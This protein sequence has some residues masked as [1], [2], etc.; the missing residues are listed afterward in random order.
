MNNAG[1]FLKLFNIQVI[2]SEEIRNKKYYEE[3]K[4]NLKTG[5]LRFHLNI[6]V[7]KE[8]EN[9]WL[10]VIKTK[11]AFIKDRLNLSSK[12]TTSCSQCSPK[13][14]LLDT[15]NWLKNNHITVA[16]MICCFGAG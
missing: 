2:E 10:N 15:G 6:D 16:I 1:L 14:S 3:N 4:G 13:E 11:I 5:K 8:K 12:I 7:R 9:S